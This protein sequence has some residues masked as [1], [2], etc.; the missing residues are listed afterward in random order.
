MEQDLVITIDIGT[1]TIKACLWGTSLEAPLAVRSIEYALDA[2][3]GR[4]EVAPEVYLDAVRGVLGALVGEVGSAERIRAVCCTTQGE[5]LI[6]VD[7][8]GTPL[9]NAIVWLDS[10]AGSD[11]ARLEEHLG[12]ERVYRTTGVARL[13]GAVPVAKVAMLRRTDPARYHGAVR[14]LLLEDFV[15][16]A[17]T[18]RTVT[19]PSLQTSTG[20]FDVGADDYWDAALRAAGIA[21]EQLPDLVESGTTVGAVLPSWC[22]VTGLADGTVVIAGAMDQTAAALA[23]GVTGP[24]V[25]NV[26]FGTALTVTA[27]LDVV[28]E[29]HPDGHRTTFYRHVV[30]QRLLAIEFLPTGAVVLRWLRD[31]L[32]RERHDYADLD[33]LAEVV[34]PGAGGVLALAHLASAADPAGDAPGGFLGVGMD[35]GPGHL[36]RGVMEATAFELH[37]MLGRLADAGCRPEDLRTSGGGARSGVWQRITADVCGI[38]LTPLTQS[39]AS[40]AGAALLALWGSGLRHRGQGLDLSG[41]PRLHPDPSLRETYDRGMRRSARVGAALAAAWPDPLPLDP[42]PEGRSR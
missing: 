6:A 30:P 8:D 29:P 7:A 41:S 9:G 1:T 27:T 33:A 20:W 15:V 38:P 19:T 18:G 16:S 25:A 23:A 40:S 32:G 12:S 14:F 35:T 10:R 4:I 39:E 31:L 24:G 17:L 42:T 36:V 28:P 3:D 21:R 2:A 11:A 22:R 26:T 37:T 34:A 13:T 5:T